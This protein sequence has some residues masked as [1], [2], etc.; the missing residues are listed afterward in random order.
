M[1]ISFSI[2]IFYSFC[3]LLF[4]AILFDPILF[5]SILFYSILFY[6]ILFYSILFYSILFYSIL[7]YSI[8]FYSLSNSFVFFLTAFANLPYEVLVVMRCGTN[9]SDSS[10]FN[11]LTLAL[12]CL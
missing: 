3:S 7:F 8:L 1:K 10:I 4:R 5:Y 2:P 12:V 11:L 6:S 9:P